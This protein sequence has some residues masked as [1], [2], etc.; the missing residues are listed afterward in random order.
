[1]TIINLTPHAIN[2]I[3][4]DGTIKT[5]APDG[6]V[7]RA[8]QILSKINNDLDFPL[9]VERVGKV[10]GVPNEIENRMILVSAMVRTLFPRRMDLASPG[11]LV[12]DSE[13]KVIGCKNFIV[14]C[15]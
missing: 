3:R 6:T 7:A 10:V 5:F 4:A 14:N 12:R 15:P 8:E 2:L 1:M 11:E 9:V 13:G